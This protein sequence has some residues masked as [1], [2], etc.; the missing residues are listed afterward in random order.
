MKPHQ[1]PNL[2]TI[3]R[4]ILIPFFLWQ[5][6]TAQ[7]VPAFYLF[8]VAGLSDGVDGFLARRFQWTSELGARMDPAADKLLMLSSFISLAI[9]HAIP[10]WLMWV[11]VLRDVIMLSGTGGV[12]YVVGDVDFNPNFIGKLNTVLQI[13]LIAMLLYQLAY[14]YLP[15][16][17][18]TILMYVVVTTTL[19]SL[20][21]YVW[22]GIQQAFY[23]NRTKS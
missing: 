2:I 4:I 23:R 16:R 1:I 6:F 18:I 3:M 14:Q 22:E 10:M 5:L 15:D 7:F 8:L 9:I 20:V 11:V 13:I 21:E 19:L 17:L 12:F